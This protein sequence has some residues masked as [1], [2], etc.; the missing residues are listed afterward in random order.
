MPGM[1][2]IVCCGIVALARDAQRHRSI[3]ENTVTRLEQ[4]R[5]SDM[6][7][8]TDPFTPT[9]ILLFCACFVGFNH[10]TYGQGAPPA[11]P[12]ASD[13]VVR[14][15]EPTAAR[16]IYTSAR[17]MGM[18]RGVGEYDVWSSLRYEGAGA[19]YEVTGANAADWPRIELSRYYVEIAYEP[20]A[21]LRSDITT[22]KG[23][24]TVW[25]VAGNAS[26]N[27][28]D[29][30][31]EGPPVGTS[32]VAAPQLRNWRQK[33]LAITPGGAIKLAHQNVKQVKVTDLGNRTYE[34][35]LPANNMKIRLNR[36]RHPELVEMTV[37]H[38][39]LRK[40]TLTAEY[41][42]Y[43]DY[44]P[45]DPLQSDEPFSGFAF[46]SRIVHKLNGRTILDVAVKTCWC[47]NPYVIFPVPENVISR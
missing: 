26:W 3:L 18:L 25:A 2:R 27:E 19:M 33:L 34:L 46:P 20:D 24:R 21:G 7:I 41:S 11:N 16:L 31:R 6:T 36:D 13:W 42:G 40:A 5:K 38:P 44:E 1:H 29:V 17:A 43:R 28:Q 47:T 4:R 35:S 22:S 9:F 37:D 32:Q 15:F 23:E 30:A 45:I 8:R 12:Q 14:S 39:V 10:F